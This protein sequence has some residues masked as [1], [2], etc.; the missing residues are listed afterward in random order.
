M[1]RSTYDKVRIGIN[2]GSLPLSAFLIVVVELFP[3][4]AI[5]LTIGTG[6]L[7]HVA[8]SNLEYWNR[9]LETGQWDS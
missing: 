9:Q 5:F 1:G 7:A 2:L 4:W 6:A 8:V 3:L